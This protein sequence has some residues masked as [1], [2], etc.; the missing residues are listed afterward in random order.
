MAATTPYLI[1]ATPF[2]TLLASTPTTNYEIPT[3]PLLTNNQINDY[4]SKQEN[5]L[6]SQMREI[7]DTQERTSRETKQKYQEPRQEN[8][9]INTAIK[10]L[11]KR[12]VPEIPRTIPTQQY[13]ATSSQGTKTIGPQGTNHTPT[14]LPSNSQSML[15]PLMFA[16]AVIL[17]IIWGF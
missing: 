16:S 13:R 6:T 8:N 7:T 3:T 17:A 2:K 14:P 5:Q 12:T 4:D 15:T 11:T 9:F 10:E 1:E